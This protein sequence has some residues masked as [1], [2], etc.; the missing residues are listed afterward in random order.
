MYIYI[1]YKI[2]IYYIQYIYYIKHIYY[3]RY[4]YLHYHPAISVNLQHCLLLKI[5]F[6]KA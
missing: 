1:L 3:I 6:H 5:C 4:T 2:Y